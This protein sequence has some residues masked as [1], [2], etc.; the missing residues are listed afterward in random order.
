MN[1]SKAL[2]A[3]REI[4]AIELPIFADLL[5]RIS[6]FRSLAG[7]AY[8]AMSG[9]AMDDQKKLYRTLGLRP[10]LS[11]DERIEIVARQRFNRPTIRSHVTIST[12][13]RFAS[14]WPKIF[15]EEGFEDAQN[16]I[17]WVRTGTSE[18]AGQGVRFFQQMVGSLA[19]GGLARITLGIDYEDWAGPLYS[20]GRRRL[21]LDRQKQVGQKVREYLA[22]FL[23]EHEMPDAMNEDSLYSAL[24]TAYGSAAAT[25]V[26]GATGRTFEPLS[27]I[28]YG[29][30]PVDLTLTGIVV[31]TA[32]RS[33]VHACIEEGGWPFA[34]RTW[35]DIKNLRL[36]DVTFR[37]R[38][39][40][41]ASA[42]DKIAAQK[43]LHFDLDEATR[44]D[45]V[46]DSF[47]RYHRYFPAMVAA[48]F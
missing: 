44:E 34:S 20:D 1:S 17:L 28:R 4:D 41:E 30:G 46:F 7:H 14:E 29:P 39:E 37:E 43:R 24:A 2:V 45:G 26:G 18:N 8:G 12:F 32:D 23:E 36:P 21:E 16:H 10:M 25:A 11:F 6:R 13:E 15:A 19:E 33:R 9:F 3:R 42:G 31:A 27:L 38:L 40:L 5:T 47:A 22:D 35:A 48:D